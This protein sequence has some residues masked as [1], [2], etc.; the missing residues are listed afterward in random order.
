MCIAKKIE[1]VAPWGLYIYILEYLT[2]ESLKA[3]HIMMISSRKSHY[4][5]YRLSVCGQC[6]PFLTLPT[7]HAA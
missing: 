3:L 7:W 1:A 4:M 5:M 2:V 6:H